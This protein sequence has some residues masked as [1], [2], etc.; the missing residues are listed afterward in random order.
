MPAWLLALIAAFPTLIPAIITII[1]Q[2]IAIF[3]QAPP[4]SAPNIVTNLQAVKTDLMS[5][6]G[7]VQAQ[8]KA[9][10]IKP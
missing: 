2:I 7:E 9:K 6:H 10:G 3:Q 4:A 5:V 1:D 8:L